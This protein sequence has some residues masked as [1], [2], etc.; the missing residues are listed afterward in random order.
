MIISRKTTGKVKQIK[1][2]EYC[3][4]KCEYLRVVI[5]EK[6]EKRKVIMGRIQQTVYVSQR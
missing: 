1:M 3:F 4:K 6:N 2:G 5:I